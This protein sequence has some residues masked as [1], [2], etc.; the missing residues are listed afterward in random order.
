MKNGLY[1]ENEEVIYYRDGKP[2]HAGVVKIDGDIYYIS[3]EG[4]AVKGQH[5]V[6]GSMSN[7]ILKRGTYTFGDDCKL[8]KGSYIA[9]KKK[10]RPRH[11]TAG[12]AFRMRQKKIISLIVVTVLLCLLLLVLTAGSVFSGEHAGWEDSIAGIGEVAAIEEIYEIQ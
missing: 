12:R 4:R 11:S 6:H 5:I 10:K 9:P 2:E 7:G 1:R 8:I 3:S